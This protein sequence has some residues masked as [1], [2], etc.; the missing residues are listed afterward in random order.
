MK[1]LNIL[2]ILPLGRIG[3]AEKFVLSLCRHHDR[4]LFNTMVCILFWG[5]TV[6]DEIR[7]TGC[8]IFRLNMVNGFDL[9]RG[10]RIVTII[11]THAIDIVNIHGQNPLG[12]FFSIIAKPAVIIHT[13]HGTTLGSNV[14]RKRRVVYF[15]RLVIPYIDRFVAISEGM[16]NSL[17]IR[18]KVPP[19]KIDLIYNGIDVDRIRNDADGKNAE[20]RD[21]LGKEI[22]GPVIGTV[23]RLSEEKR[24]HLLI[25][26]MAIL[27]R[28]SLR[29]TLIIIGDGP[30]RSVLRQYSKSK[31]LD[32]KVHFLGSRS[33]VYRLLDFIDIFAFP[34]AG[35][36][37]SLTLLEAMAKSIPIVAY[38]VEGVNEAV[39][40]GINGYLV[41]DGEKE[42]FAEKVD[43]LIA[44]PRLGK[45][46]GQNGFNIVHADFN[47]KRNIAKL[48]HLYVQ[49]MEQRLAGN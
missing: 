32:S 13:D 6:A 26:S 25:D 14:Q 9:F 15:N 11:N 18:E 21:I 7:E 49:L 34:S 46:L 17:Q 41:R 24:L 3:G 45:E 33:D 2:Y 36:A 19:E 44:N 39:K 12:K 20:L 35:E 23:G 22:T 27:H 37:F 5:D 29:F 30:L 4:R 48:E 1:R 47:I 8:R 42:A 43:Y 16:N 38:D 31:G 28:K 40:D 10:R